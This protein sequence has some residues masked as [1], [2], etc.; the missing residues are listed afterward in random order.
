MSDPL[1]EAQRR[2]A[3]FENLYRGA[4]LGNRS[5]AKGIKRL[6]VKLARREAKVCALRK[7]LH[8]LANELEGMRAF[9]SEVVAVIGRTNWNVLRLRID[10]AHAALWEKP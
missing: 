3:Y 4:S 2:C 9:E 5:S 10:E 1:A 6:K 8:Q 7:T